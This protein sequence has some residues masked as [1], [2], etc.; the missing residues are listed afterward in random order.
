MRKMFTWWEA[1]RYC[2]T[3]TTACVFIHDR[4]EN[5]LLASC[6]ISDLHSCIIITRCKQRSK[7]LWTT[8]FRFFQSKLQSTVNSECVRV[9]RY[10]SA[11]EL[12]NTPI[13]IAITSREALLIV[14]A[15]TVTANLKKIYRIVRENSKLCGYLNLNSV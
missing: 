5:K 9:F 2:P 12:H 7:Y 14:H 1:I 13:W 6:A 15:W 4:M 8:G 3:K 11:G 10:V